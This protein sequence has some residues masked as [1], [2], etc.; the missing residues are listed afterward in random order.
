MLGD[1]HPLNKIKEIANHE[2]KR[3]LRIRIENGKTYVSLNHG[4]WLVNN[5]DAL[6]E[7]MRLILDVL[8][9]MDKYDLTI[10]ARKE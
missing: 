9:S 4:V 2:R 1:Q 7:D 10:D 3:N 5:Y 8:C 6:T